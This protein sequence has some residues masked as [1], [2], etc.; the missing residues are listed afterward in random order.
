MVAEEVEEHEVTTT[1]TPT[2]N[3]NEDNNEEDT[4]SD[5]EITT[6]ENAIHFGNIRDRRL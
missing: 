4:L 5:V 2:T 3:A 1:E 6:D